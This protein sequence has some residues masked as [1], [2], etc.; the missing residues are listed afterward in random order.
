MALVID[1]TGVIDEIR[2][3][4]R[5]TGRGPMVRMQ[6]ERQGLV[7]HERTLW[8]GFFVESSRRF[9]PFE[10]EHEAESFASQR[11]NWLERSVRRSVGGDVT[12]EQFTFTYP[13]P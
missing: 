12:A 4:W 5:D 11:A 10:T 3:L 2:A 6:I 13:P 8:Q 9:G 1:H 7:V